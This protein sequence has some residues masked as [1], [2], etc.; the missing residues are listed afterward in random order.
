MLSSTA[1]YQ[2]SAPHS[3]KQPTGWAHQPERVPRRDQ[4]AVAGPS[5]FG[6]SVDLYT[7]R[8]ISLVR[9]RVWRCPRRGRRAFTCV[10]DLI[11]AI[12]AFIDAYNQRCEPFRWTKTADQ[13]LSKANRQEEL[14]HG[15]PASTRSGE[16][17]A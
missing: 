6:E 15:T 12:R 2:P 1:P 9:E 7:D 13:I 5:Q 8:P 17:T 3:P 10:P 16:A 4:A 14:R 11:G